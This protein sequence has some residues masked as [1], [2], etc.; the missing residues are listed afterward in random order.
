[1]R[2]DALGFC[3]FGRGVK[4]VVGVLREVGSTLEKGGQRDLMGCSSND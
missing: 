1:M 4:V 3:G 2:E